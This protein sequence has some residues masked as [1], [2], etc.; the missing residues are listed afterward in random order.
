MEENN[1]TIREMDIVYKPRK[2][3]KSIATIDS[4][5][6][7]HDLLKQFYNKNTLACQEE[8][9]VLYVNQANEP[10]GVY[11]VGKGGIS[12]TIADVRL[13]MA[14]ALKALATGL[15]ISHNHPSGALSPSGA[16]RRLTNKLKEA[17]KLMD[18]ELL[19]HLILTPYEGYYSFADYGAL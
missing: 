4:S 14:T 9:I 2:K 10:L 3:K 5:A 18:I 6:K 1:F 13:V 19:D 12:S 15:I 7:A 11:K 17:C 8:F 16:D